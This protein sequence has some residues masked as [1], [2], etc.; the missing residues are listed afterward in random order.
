MDSRIEAKLLFAGVLSFL[1]FIAEL[2]HRQ[3][4]PALACAAVTTSLFVLSVIS[5]HRKPHHRNGRR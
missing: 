4:L 2:L 1:L 5:M 3:W